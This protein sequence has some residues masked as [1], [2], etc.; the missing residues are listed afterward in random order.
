MQQVVTFSIK[1][2]EGITIDG[3]MKTLGGKLRGKLLGTWHRLHQALSA[4]VDQPSV[5]KPQALGYYDGAYN[6]AYASMPA[7]S[8]REFI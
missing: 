4:P 3:K 7:I 8:L 6:R 1:F 2:E 5:S